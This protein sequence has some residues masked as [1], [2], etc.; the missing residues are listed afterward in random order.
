MKHHPLVIGSALSGLVLPLAAWAQ[1]AP[2]APAPPSYPGWGMPYYGHMWGGGMGYGGFGWGHLLMWLLL[3]AAVVAV[4]LLARGTGGGRHD[5]H[6][7]DP[8]HSALQILNERYARGEIEKAEYEEKKA[9][10][11]AGG[12]R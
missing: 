9:A 4:Y 5:P 12:R 1:Q 2:G 11:L 8:A 7:D 10:L 6:R 3:I